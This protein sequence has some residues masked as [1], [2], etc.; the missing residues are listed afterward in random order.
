MSKEE[1]PEEQV[2]DKLTPQE[3]QELQQYLSAGAPAPDEKHN[4]HKFLSEVATSEDTTK[5]GYLDKEEVGT[6][7]HPTRTY[8]S[9]ALTADKIMGNSFL[10]DFFNAEAEILSSTSLSKDAK[11]LEV[12]IT[13]TRQLGD[14]TKKAK[15]N[16]GW[17]G[18]KDKGGT[19]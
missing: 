17:F 9:L 19:E 12:A 11:L 4:I 1:Q 10:K 5:T 2:T 14:V 6:P 13:S 16:K 8:K 15:P 7:T 3:A 18:K